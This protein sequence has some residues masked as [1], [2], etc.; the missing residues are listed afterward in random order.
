MAQ[1]YEGGVPPEAPEII[2][3]G[4]E[5]FDRWR[6]TVGLFAGPIT[7]F[8]I[9]ILPLS[10]LTPQA[11]RLAAILG[12]VVVYWITEP[13]PIP[14]TALL[15]PIL[16]I[17][18]AVGPTKEVLA[19]FANPIIFLFIGSFFLAQAMI[20][21][22]LDR[23]IALGILS[24]KWIG[25]SATRLLFAFG[26]ITAA[27]SMWISN[28]AA[29]AMMFPIA[30]GIL[31]AVRETVKDSNDPFTSATVGR[32]S[33]GFMLMVAYAASVGGI[34]TLIG[35]PPNLIGAGLI[36]QQIG[37][38]ITFVGWM[39]FGLP[40]LL[41]MYGCLFV[42]LW[43]LH[44]PRGLDL[45]GV[46]TFI[47]AQRSRLGP[48]TVG[49]RNAAFAFLLAVGLWVTPGGIALLAGTESAAYRWYDAHIPESI[50]AL[51][52]AGMLFLLPVN[53]GKRQFTLTWNEASKIDW[54]TIL[55][56]GGGL[57]LGDL[58]FK[59]GLAETLGRGGVDFLALDSLWGLTAMAILLGILISELTSNTASASMVIPV[60]IAI[61]EAIG[62]S[63]L[64]PALGACLGA[65]YGF[66]LPISTP[67]NA[68]VY[69]SGLIPITRMIRAGIL[70]DILGF[71]IIWLGLRLL[72]PL[73]GY[74]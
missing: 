1:W 2:S 34:G 44:P 26:A 36:Q 28:T 19:P 4:E 15:G 69:G 8:I 38:K 51:L 71:F 3:P 9:L 30:L 12:F 73:L 39:T 74:I 63:P 33:T 6:K 31:S 16:C 72:C 11:H 52:A 43:I 57:S 21:H 61:A 27:L 41:I 58:M 25:A 14:I 67:P 68:I 23:R 62:V 42:L 35:T 47:R 32:Y 60:V 20:A 13:I 70:L 49:Q 40:L 45:S 50:V 48:W 24:W 22:G 10:A 29:T 64:P 18:T 7:A 56:F 17:M 37:V 66:M 46:E 54:G 65:S 53:W 59:T 55:L 5:R